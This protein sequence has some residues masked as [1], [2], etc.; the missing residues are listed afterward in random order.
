MAGTRTPQLALWVIAYA[1]C[2]RGEGRAPFPDPLGAGARIFDITTYGAVG[3]NATI[4]TGAVQ[5]AID[6]ASAAGGG[7]V[8]VPPGG[9]FR[10]ATISLASDVYLFLPSG[11]TLIGSANYSDYYAI[12][13][14][15]WD[16]WDVV[17]SN[18]ATRTGIV[19]DA[20]GGG[21]LSG[22]MWQM[23]TGY[24][25]S[26]NQFVPQ[27]WL[28]DG[29]EGECRPRL[30][31]FEDCDDVTVAN[32]RLVDSAD[33]TQLYRRSNR[34]R[35]VNMS[36]WGSQQWPNNDGV[37]FESCADVVVRNVSM[38]TGD[39]SV[40]LASGNCNTMARPWPEPPGAYSPTR[41]VLI[42]NV[43]LSSYSSALKWEAIFQ[44]DHGNVTNVTVRN[45]LIHD[46]A[47]GIGF[48]QRTGSGAFTD[49]LLERVTVLRTH[50]ITGSNWWGLG[51]A[52]WAT[53]VPENGT[54][55]ALG[56]IHN[57]T[58]VDCVLQGEQGV[59]VASRDQGNAS[60][61]GAA[62]SGLRFLNVTVIVGTYG[63]ATRPG[64]HDFRPMDAG[65]PTPEKVN[66]SVAGYWFEHA[67]GI[68]VEGGA[69]GFEGPP[70]PWWAPGST[71]WAASPDS[72]VAVRGL[73]C[74]PP[75]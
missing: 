58:L 15:D 26:Q 75:S 68:V 56:G 3:D 71:C 70:Q 48:Q 73:A 57:V 31:V 20:S 25:P 53:S 60:A 43:T 37:D 41:D 47:R 27:I 45:V 13:K 7:Y 19:G 51:E 1:C 67:A 4:N 5:A 40:V 50:G 21:V 61:T 33:W 64:V 49:V 29:C 16:R 32:V 35:L 63:N 28:V 74:N 2:V 30:L 11:A 65:Q 42:E 17:H 12:D 54:E 6:A 59:V 55:H 66:A 44:R 34:V 8:L 22:P 23:I 46:S 72:R 52:F 14:G 39:D 9:A 36:V 62:I 38:F 10:T 18:N 24:D 69:V